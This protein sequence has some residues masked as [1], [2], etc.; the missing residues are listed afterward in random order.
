M[1]KPKNKEEG[2]KTTKTITEEGDKRIE[3]IITKE[4]NKTTTHIITTQNNV[5]YNQLN[6]IDI[7]PNEYVLDSKESDLID[8][9]ISELI[10]E[11]EAFE[12]GQNQNQKKIEINKKIEIE[13]EDTGI[14]EEEEIHKTKKTQYEMLDSE[15]IEKNSVLYDSNS[16]YTSEVY[17]E[18][19]LLTHRSSNNNINININDNYSPLLY[20]EEITNTSNGANDITE[21]EIYNLGAKTIQSVFRGYILRKVFYTNMQYY[22]DL[23]WSCTLLES[24]LRIKRKKRFFYCLRY[25]D[26]NKKKTYMKNILNINA[27]KLPKIFLKKKYAMLTDYKIIHNNSLCFIPKRKR[28]ITKTTIK[29]Y[30]ETKIEK[31]NIIP[32][33]FEKEFIKIKKE[34]EK[35]K[36]ENEALKIR[37]EYVTEEYSKEI[38][39]TYNEIK[40]KY[41]FKDEDGKIVD[42]KHETVV[43]QPQNLIDLF[44]RLEKELNDANN[45][46]DKLKQ[47]NKKFD[48]K[49]DKIISDINNIIENQKKITKEN[50][51]TTEQNINEKLELITTYLNELKVERVEIENLKNENEKLKKLLKEKKNNPL[52]GSS[53][54]FGKSYSKDEDDLE[55]KIDDFLLKSKSLYDK[56]NNQNLEEDFNDKSINFKSIYSLLQDSK[57]KIEDNKNE[58]I[59]LKKENDNL[60][61]NLKESININNNEDFQ[62]LIRENEELKKLIEEKNKEI[63]KLREQCKKALSLSDKIQKNKLLKELE[64]DEINK[65]KEERKKLLEISS[66]RKK[67]PFE[68]INEVKKENAKLKEQVNQLQN[69]ID[70]LNKR[71]QLRTKDEKDI[72]LINQLRDSCEHLKIELNQEKEFTDKY[73]KEKIILNNK[74][75]ETVLRQLLFNFMRKEEKSLLYNFT[76]FSKKC[77]ENSKEK[78][79]KILLKEIVQNYEKDKSY[80]TRKYFLKFLRNGILKEM[81]MTNSQKQALEKRKN[82]MKL[83]HEKKKLAEKYDKENPEKAKKIREEI[84]LIEEEDKKK[85]LHTSIISPTLTDEEKREIAK[86]KYLKDLF[87]NKLKAKE[88]FIHNAFNKF[89][90]RGLFLRM[91]YGNKLKDKLQIPEIKTENSNLKRLETEKSEIDESLQDSNSENITPKQKLEEQ[92]KRARA[93]RKHLKD[94]KDDDKKNKDNISDNEKDI[95]E[96]EFLID[97]ETGEVID[98]KTN[99][100]HKKHKT[101]KELEIE[102]LLSKFLYKIERVNNGVMRTIFTKWNYITKLIKMKEMR[103]VRKPKRRKKNKNIIEE[104]EDLKE[105]SNTNNL[106]DNKDKDDENDFGND[107]NYQKKPSFRERRK[108]QKEKEEKEKLENESKSNIKYKKFNLKEVQSEIPLNKTDKKNNNLEEV[109]EDEEYVYELMDIND[110]IKKLIKLSKIVHKKINYPIRKCLNYWLYLIQNS[111]KEKFKSI[112]KFFGISIEEGDTFNLTNLLSMLTSPDYNIFSTVI[113]LTEEADKN[114]LKILGNIAK[115]KL[116]H[117]LKQSKDE[118]LLDNDENLKIQKESKVIIKQNENENN[119]F[120]DKSGVEIF[121]ETKTI[122]TKTKIMRKKKKPNK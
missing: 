43:E 70:L 59:G 3:T 44:K 111:D 19:K 49:L 42:E 41:I 37:I 10:I 39:S 40:I 81:N 80:N 13:E 72:E 99:K 34:N 11:T 104:D 18:E 117:Y 91:K 122:T 6:G 74:L 5:E 109:N 116:I 28:N 32:E 100:K 24:I 46:I 23:A 62:N 55:K 96:E 35:L 69:E 94:K 79:L 54:T 56:S 112:H 113:K 58:I 83:K 68:E 108:L 115:R 45:Y 61:N 77:F 67:I 118:K 103:L 50:K 85:L 14:K 33:D 57:E 89:Y 29:E 21:E 53:F 4:G 106:N 16:H 76:R 119:E 107:E 110:E 7:L 1:D 20:R 73:K 8:F 98:K 101:V 2:T 84:E 64:Q 63:E 105:E 27:R 36:E 26:F 60:K 102:E 88:H 75:K 97:K 48:D 47:E 30:N 121:K 51:T 22:L 86:R 95:N 25:Y 93:L 66:K 120:E 38:H 87:Y 52:S 71:K 65:S 78:L 31:K 114:I 15:Q 92:R 17:E 90:Y 9:P 12:N 82:E